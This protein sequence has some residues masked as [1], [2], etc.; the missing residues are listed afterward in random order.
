M[1]FNEEKANMI[2]NKIEQK[3]VSGSK[4]PRVRENIECKIGK[5]EF[6]KKKRK[7]KLTISGLHQFQAIFT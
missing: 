3:R 1:E 4:L 5:R 2:T 7:N 6:K